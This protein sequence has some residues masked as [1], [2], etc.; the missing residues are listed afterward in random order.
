MAFEWAGSAYDSVT[1]ETKPFA[2]QR[3]YT[4]TTPLKKTSKKTHTQILYLL[5]R[6][7]QLARKV[8]IQVRKKNI[9]LVNQLLL[10]NLEI[11]MR[12]ALDLLDI[13]SGRRVETGVHVLKFLDD[14]TGLL[15]AH[16]DDAVQSVYFG[17]DSVEFV[18]LV[19][20]VDALGA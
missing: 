16:G 15:L 3:T 12:D 14:E 7:G 2:V 4:H 8:L 19:V 6:S 5:R 1:L 10:H 20:V 9:N 17:E 18:A 11:I 13:H